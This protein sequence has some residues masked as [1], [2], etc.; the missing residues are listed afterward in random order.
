MP[1]QKP[2]RIYGTSPPAAWGIAGM[3][4]IFLAC[5]AVLVIS[6]LLSSI[7]PELRNTVSG[8][9]LFTSDRDGKREIYRLSGRG[10]ERI[11]FTS[12][13]SESWDAVAAPD[14]SILFTSNRDGKREIYRLIGD[15]TK[16]ITFTPGSAESWDPAAE[17]GGSLLFS[18]NR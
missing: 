4:L 1:T 17:S 10:A 14:G 16:R 11:T 12:G 7:S 3:A 6:I 18:S 5:T 8:E 13:D 9:L 2:V 15:V